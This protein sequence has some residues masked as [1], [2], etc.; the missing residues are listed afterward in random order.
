MSIGSVYEY[1]RDKQ[2]IVNALLDAHLTRGESLLAARAARVVDAPALP[3]PQ[4]VSQVVEA[5]VALHADD[6]KLHRVLSSEVPLTPAIRRR[7]RELNERVVAVVET[8]LRSHPEVRVSDPSLAARL[9]VDTCDALS[10]R[11]LVDHAGKELPWQRLA[12][13]LTRLLV[14]YLSATG[15]GSSGCSASMSGQPPRA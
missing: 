2:A 15:Q 14:N 9:V 3:L 11:W 1:F 7:V 5:F 12:N 4:V 6:P 13:E 8:L 10:H